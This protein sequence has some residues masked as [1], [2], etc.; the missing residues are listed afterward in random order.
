MD[1]AE[2]RLRRV[3]AEHLPAVAA[4][5]RHRL[6]PLDVSDLDDILEECLVVAWR[7][8]DDCPVDSE[9]AWLIGVARNIMSNARRSRQRQIRLLSRLRAAEPSPSAEMWVLASSSIREAMAQLSEI[10]RDVLMLHHWEGLRAREIAL[11]LG[12]SR[13]AAEARL[14]RAQARLRHAI[15]RGAGIVRNADTTKYVE[16]RVGDGSDAEHP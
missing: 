13:K 7:R 2:V 8:L 11:A 15:E 9:R 4:Y 3:A 5:V 1:D 10:D 16:R 6:Y 14:T 12:L